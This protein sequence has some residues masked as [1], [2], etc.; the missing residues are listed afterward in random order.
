MNK[1]CSLGI[2]LS[3]FLAIA[4]IVGAFSGCA[5][6]Q[7]QN[8]ESMLS[9]AGFQTQIPSTPQQLWLYNRMTPY[10][11]ERTTLTDKV[12]YTY[13]DKQKGVVYIGGDKAYQRYKQLGIQ[14]AIAQKELEA[15]DSN[16]YA[17]I[18]QLWAVHE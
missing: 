3:L 12:L 16:Y 6:I 15:A 14:Q 13:V 8:K 5:G 4:A 2:C 7:A 9:A 1:S 17:K 18:D 11:L 10:K